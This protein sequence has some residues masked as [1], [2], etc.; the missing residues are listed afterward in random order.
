MKHENKNDLIKADIRNQ[1]LTGALSPGEALDTDAVLGEKYSVSRMT[2]RKAIDE[3][4]L[5]GYLTRIYKKGAFVNRRGRFEGF[6]FGL[7]YS[8]EMR[9]RGMKPASR[10]VK[11]RLELPC[12]REI[13]DLRLLPSHRVW[14]VNRLRLADD[15]PVAYEDSYFPYPLIGELTE[16]DAGG[17]IAELMERRYGYT[18]HSADQWIDAVCADAELARKLEVPAGTPLV[19]TFSIAYLTNGTPFN[20][21]SCYYRTDS[22]K[23]IQSIHV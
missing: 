23:L 5:E 20:C 3:L 7:G 15:M 14:H 12:P 19:R 21:G 8:E 22:F 4:V 1:I 17:S 16:E 18:F 11:V 13:E 2:V 10:N 9:R 6:R